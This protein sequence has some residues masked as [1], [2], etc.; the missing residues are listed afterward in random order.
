MDEDAPD[1]GASRVSHWVTDPEDWARFSRWMDEILDLDEPLR[2][3]RLQRLEHDEPRLAVRMHAALRAARRAQQTGFLSGTLAAGLDEPGWVDR[4]IGIYRIERELGRGGS[5]TVWLA[6]RPGRRAAAP[7]AIKLLHPSLAGRSAEQR[8]RQESALQAGLCHPHIA[9]WRHAGVTPAGQPYLVLEYVD[10]VSIVQ[11]CDEHRL[12]LQPRLRLVLQLMTALE[13]VHAQQLVH[14]DVKPANVLVTRA[15]Q[16]KLLDFGIAKRLGGPEADH[17]PVTAEGRPVMTPRYAAPEQLLGEPVTAAVDIYALGVLMYELLCGRSPRGDAVDTVA[18]MR[19][20]VQD[21]PPALAQALQGDAA[22]ATVAAAARGTTPERL[23][24]DLAGDLSHLVAQAMHKDVQGRYASVAACADDVRRYL[25][26]EPVSAR[27]AAADVPR[28]PPPPDLL[29]ALAVGAC[30][31][32]AFA[33]AFV[34]ASRA[35]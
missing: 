16:V 1:P 5:G 8:F 28:E 22:A 23:Q 24:Q 21:A 25:R 19:Q 31:G 12:G 35:F 27:P 26:G 2:R 18:W 3:E 34:L 32:T 30:L 10:G 6:R 13:H 15:G 4:R 7:V 17:P 33:S 11:H 9:R 14:R 29:A 20:A